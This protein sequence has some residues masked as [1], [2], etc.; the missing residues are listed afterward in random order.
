MA[1]AVE[2]ELDPV[3]DEPFAVEPLGDTGL[4]EQLH[5]ALL[6]DAG[7]DPVLDVLAASVLQHD[8]LDPLDLEQA[9]EREPGRA[10]SDDPDLRPHPSSS[11]RCATAKAPLAA[12]TPQ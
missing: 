4:R 9:R 6:E 1:L 11:T 7:A 5:R 2:L 12:G 8:R 3:V 10:G